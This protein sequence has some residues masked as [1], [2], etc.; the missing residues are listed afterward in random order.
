MIDPNPGLA[1]VSGDVFRATSR[2]H[3]TAVNRGGLMRRL[4][5]R[6]GLSLAAGI[7]R[8]E[9]ISPNEVV[10]AVIL[11]ANGAREIAKAA[12]DRL[13]RS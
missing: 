5:T 1:S 12:F 9:P 2:I 6:L 7:Q 10:Y 11:R 4:A 13:R 8:P 3:W